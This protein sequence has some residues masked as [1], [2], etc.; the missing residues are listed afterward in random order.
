MNKREQEVFLCAQLAE[1]KT[2]GNWF[3]HVALKK[4]GNCVLLLL[5]S[6]SVRSLA[7]ADGKADLTEILGVKSG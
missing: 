4:L 3:R 1:L 5:L 6:H 7:T 2:E